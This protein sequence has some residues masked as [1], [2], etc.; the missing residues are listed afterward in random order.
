MGIETPI[1]EKTRTTWSADAAAPQRREHAE[2]YP[3]DGRDQHRGQRELG[4]GGSVRPQVGEDRALRLFRGAK[5]A[6]Q[7]PAQVRD[8][9]HGQR[10]VEPVPH[11]EGVDRRRVV[12]RLL[13][14]VGDRRVAG[15]ELRQHEGDEADPQ[16]EAD[17]RHEPTR[18]EYRNRVTRPGP[19][20]G[21]AARQRH[22][23]L[24]A[25]A[26]KS[27]YQTEL[28][29]TPLRLDVDTIDSPG[30]TSG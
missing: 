5:V 6:V 24:L 29:W 22:R 17:D 8:V 18:D 15:H 4:R 12:G 14:Q 19:G 3:A 11:V 9:L 1:S 21:P 26:A 2:A 20:Q 10:A 27:R 13:P 28:Y 16:R 23:H 25:I 30:N 7:Q